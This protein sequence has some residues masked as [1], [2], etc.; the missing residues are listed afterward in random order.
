MNN[1]NTTQRQR[2]KKLTRFSLYLCGPMKDCKTEEELHGW[3][4]RL[5][6]LLIEYP[7][8]IFDPTK[9]DYRKALRETM[10]LHEIEKIDEEIITIDTEEI[11]S[12]HALIGNC[13]QPSAGSSMEIF[14]A[15]CMKKFVVSVV[16]SFGEASP[17]IRYHSTVVVENYVEAIAELRKVFPQIFGREQK[18]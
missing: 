15:W 7:I 1:L 10:F 17:W 14:L 5:K 3:R 4:D 18:G 11:M 9:R 12:S 13:F 2:L 16:P 8:T 6:S